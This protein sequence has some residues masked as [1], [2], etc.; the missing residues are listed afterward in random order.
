MLCTHCSRSR[1]SKSSYSPSWLCRHS[2]VLPHHL[3]CPFPVPVMN[4]WIVCNGRSLGGEFCI[5]SNLLHYPHNW[6]GSLRPSLFGAAHTTK[7]GII[8]DEKLRGRWSQ[9]GWRQIELRLLNRSLARE[10]LTTRAFISCIFRF[11][12]SWV[13]NSLNDL[14]ENLAAHPHLTR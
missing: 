11:E 2:P 1:G 7:S 10:G 8:V 14:S 12:F 3:S 9:C 5:A 4:G 6:F 13:R